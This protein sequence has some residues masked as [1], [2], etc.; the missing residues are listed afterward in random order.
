MCTERD[1]SKCRKPKITKKIKEYNIKQITNTLIIIIIYLIIWHKIVDYFVFRRKID[2]FIF[3][4]CHFG[5]NGKINYGFYQSFNNI[6]Y[7]CQIYKSLENKLT[8]RRNL[9]VLK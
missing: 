5:W 8:I 6:M 3:T 1:T 2:N 9:T 7:L 4:R